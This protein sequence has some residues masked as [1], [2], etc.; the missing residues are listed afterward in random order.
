M[1]E[2]HSRED[3]YRRLPIRQKLILR[4]SQRSVAGRWRRWATRAALRGAAG[5][6]AVAAAGAANYFTRVPR[7]D[8]RPMS[9]FKRGRHGQFF[10]SGSEV[11]HKYTGDHHMADSGVPRNNGGFNTYVRGRVRSGRRMRIGRKKLIAAKTEVVP[12]LLRYSAISP[13]SGTAGYHKL[14]N[15]R[16][17]TSGDLWLPVHLYDLTAIVN[18]VFGTVCSMPV[19]YQPKILASNLVNFYN[20][21]GSK[22]DGTDYAKSYYV[23]ERWEDRYT[24]NNVHFGARAFHCWVQIKL[25][26]YSIL[27]TPTRFTV[28]MVQFNDEDCLPD[29]PNNINYDETV[30][31]TVVTV[32]QRKPGLDSAQFWADMMKPYVYNPIATN[33][34]NWRSKYKCIKK[35]DF[36]VQPRS[37][38]NSDTTTPNTVELSWF[39]NFNS[40]RKYLWETKRGATL[41]TDIQNDDDFPATDNRDVSTNVDPSKRIYLMIK[42]TALPQTGAADWA[43]NSAAVNSSHPTY[44]IL[45]RN[46]YYNC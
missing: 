44:D 20:L 42:A 38:V 40:S 5:L 31:D 33:I 45:I 22:P 28:E 23:M 36:L 2:Y 9:H 35:K 21:N 1:R 16:N 15:Y 24:N 19:G 11:T 26:L 27:T 3:W 8:T 17:T 7:L 25:V 43:Q 12:R 46:K 18:N 13:Y 14:V 4:H 30:S 39:H 34:G 10:A 37:T 41:N 32:S 6:G 29:D